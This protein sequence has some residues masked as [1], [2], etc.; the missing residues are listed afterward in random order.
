[1]H[2]TFDECDYAITKAT[3][4]A[5]ASN[6]NAWRPSE[7]RESALYWSLEVVGSYLVEYE[8]RQFSDEIYFFYHESF[9]IVDLPRRWKDLVGL[10]ITWDALNKN[11]SDNCVPMLCTN[12]HEEIPYSKLRFVE[13]EGRNIRIQWNGT[14]DKSPFSIDCWATFEGIDVHCNQEDDAAMIQS[15]LAAHLEPEDF[16]GHPK[17]PAGG[18]AWFE[19]RI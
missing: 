17:Y 1:M 13:V 15:I 12:F 8:G 16:I 3:I 11:V 18:I 7:I 9:Q 6:P 14:I 10:E 19:P 2:L 5:R 4:S